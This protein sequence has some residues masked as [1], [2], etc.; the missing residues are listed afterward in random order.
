[1]FAADS[2]LQVACKTSHILL[3]FLFLTKKKKKYDSLPVDALRLGRFLPSYIQEVPIQKSSSLISI[4]FFFGLRRRLSG[5]SAR[6]DLRKE[7]RET[8]KKGDS[9][10]MLKDIF[11]RLR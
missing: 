5:L 3:F 10:L 11:Y 1:M 8:E 9:S 6:K 2:Q 7:N 4:F